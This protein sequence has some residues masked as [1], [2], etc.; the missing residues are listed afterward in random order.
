MNIEKMEKLHK[1]L[2]ASVN[3]YIAFAVII[4]AVMI[5]SAIA[6]QPRN[7]ALFMLALAFVSIGRIME[8]LR[9]FVDALIS[10]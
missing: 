4:V 7:D 6:E 1:S 2:R 10:D 5:F 8:A 9:D 3:F